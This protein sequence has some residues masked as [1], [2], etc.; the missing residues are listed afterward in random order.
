MAAVLDSLII[1]VNAVLVLSKDFMLSCNALYIGVR[2]GH[3]GI[4]RGKETVSHGH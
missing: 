2:L 1:G 4:V 3:Y